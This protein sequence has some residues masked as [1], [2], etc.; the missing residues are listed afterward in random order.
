MNPRISKYQPINTPPTIPQYI[1]FSN[2]VSD[3]FSSDGAQLDFHD[4]C[5]QIRRLFSPTISSTIGI[6]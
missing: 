3:I 2:P 5:S 4:S 6:I 1:Q